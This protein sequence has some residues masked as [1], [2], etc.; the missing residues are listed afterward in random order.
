LEE[1]LQSIDDQLAD[2]ATYQGDP[3]KVVQLNLQREKAQKALEKRFARWEELAER[4][5]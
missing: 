3:D 1:Q 5:V 4:D 2:T